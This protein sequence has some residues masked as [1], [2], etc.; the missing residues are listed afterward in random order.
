M[1]IAVRGEGELVMRFID[2][3]GQTLMQ[4]RLT[5][6]GSPKVEALRVVEFLLRTQAGTPPSRPC[7]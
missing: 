2:K 6:S 1:E 4:E 7:W 5:V 3:T